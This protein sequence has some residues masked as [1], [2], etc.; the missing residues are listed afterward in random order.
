MAHE[1]DLLQAAQISALKAARRAIGFA[2]QGA[3]P[4]QTVARNVRTQIDRVLPGGEL[5]QTR[6]LLDDMVQTNVL[7]SE[8]KAFLSGEE[9]RRVYEKVKVA[10]MQVNEQAESEIEQDSDRPSA[11]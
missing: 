11:A 9:L 1:K 6:A 3:L 10:P 8:K 7:P 2:Q 4:S 5:Q